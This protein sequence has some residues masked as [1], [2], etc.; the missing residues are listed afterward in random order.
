MGNHEACFVTGTMSQSRF[1]TQINNLYETV[2]CMQVYFGTV[3]RIK[4]TH[5]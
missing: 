2:S 4:D 1:M 3:I 5:M